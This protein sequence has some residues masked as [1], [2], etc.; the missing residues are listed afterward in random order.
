MPTGPAWS[1]KLR[2][3]IGQAVIGQDAIVE[4][5]LVALL[6]NGHVLLEGMP[7]LA[8]TLLVRSL[9]TALGVQF[10]RIQFT[11]DLLP[12]DVVGTMIFQPKTGEFSPHR[13]PIFANLVLADEINR[14][15]AKVQSALLEAM[16]E[17]QV[18]V[19]GQTHPLPQP[20]FV[21]ATQNP[22]E[23]EGTYPL[24]EAQ[25]DRFLFKLI[26]DYPSADEE[27]AMMQRWGQL[28]KQPELKAVS[29][30]EELLAL[31][32]EVD[33]VH[34]A[35]TVQGYILSLVRSTRA[36]AETDDQTK[37]YL[38]FGASPR[39]SLA[40]Y[41]AGRAL[42]W[43]R[44]QD[45]VSPAL[46]QELAPEVFR[47]RVGLTYEA[48]AEEVTADKIIAEVLAKTPVPAVAKG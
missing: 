7:G 32:A 6:A 22:I 21:M 35:P 4:R 10:E 9:G 8:K 11:P 43:L 1:Q 5:L 29:S 23:Q 48:E 25:T 2:D 17:R 34:V 3:E 44:G 46:I 27:S 47:H 16:Q 40:L 24:P 37:R 15:P 20:F 18:T 39:A 42:A 12:S 41:S 14:A 45:Y 28:T 31:R 36:L 19:G 38:N 30:G 13:G 33:R 26:V